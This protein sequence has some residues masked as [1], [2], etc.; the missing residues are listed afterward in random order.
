MTQLTTVSAA[1]KP[2]R[3]APAAPM[4]WEQTKAE[5]LKLLRIPYFSVT[6]LALPVLFY[7]FFG[8]PNAHSTQQGVLVSKYLLASFGAYGVLSVM[9]FSFGVSVATE[10]GQKLNVLIRATPLP[11]WVFL[12]AKVI[13][14]LAFTV[15]M[16]LILFVFAALAGGV[17]MDALTWATLTVRLLTGAIP[18]IALGFAI[19]Y[20]AGP[21]SAA[22]V[23]NL[24]FLV[25]SFAS[26]LFV[27][28][29]QMP[30]FIQRL[31][32]Y[33]PTYRYAQLVWSA[34]GAD[35]G[36]LRPAVIWLIG[37]TVVF[38][39]LALRGYRREDDKT[40]G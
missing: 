34:I 5:F 22:A 30:N 7:I 27:P 26:G 16:L 25:L 23:T 24:L 38:T 9:L 2:V 33:L 39:I 20:W 4:L 8:L 12:L 10:R 35:V 28:L 14:A 32:P 40:F 15:I 17:R 29:S 13:T 6:S 3:V 1:A 11:A 36:A 21:N 19:G 37:Y 18:F 31:A